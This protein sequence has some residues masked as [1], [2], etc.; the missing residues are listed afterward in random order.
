[1]TKRDEAADRA[2][3]DLASTRSGHT[4]V[5][6]AVAIAIVGILAGM[7][8]TAIQP[9]VDRF[10]MLKAARLLHSDLQSL[11]ALAIS[12]NRETRIVFLVADDALDPDDVQVG[13]WLLQAG[14]RSTGSVEWDTLPIDEGAA[15]NSQGERSL[16]DDGADEAPHIS[17]A[18][19]PT[20]VGP[21]T[22]NA[23]AIVFSPR[24]WVTNPATDFADGYVALRIVNKRALADGRTEEATLRLS[25]GGLARLELGDSS[26]LP[27][28][29]VGVAEATAP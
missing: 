19:W 12:S 9:E 21:G 28:T 13:E 11:R 16:S 10:R 8:W 14:D 6:L 17:L 15:D 1:M 5:E 3:S 7:G 20:L 2:G 22:D 18:R 24:G 26:T 27:T 25:R 29:T 23:D 4:L